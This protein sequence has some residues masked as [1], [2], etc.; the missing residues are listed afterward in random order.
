MTGDQTDMVA[1]LKAVLPRGW[2]ADDTPLLDGVLAG[3][4]CGWAWLYQSLQ[5]VIT[6]TRIATA[7]DVW[8]DVIA[9]DYFGRRLVRTPGQAD[10]PF[11]QRI[12]AEL[13]RER[14]TRAAI[15]SVLE[16][17]TGRSPV[18]FEPA[19][20]TDTGAYGTTA[21]GW[22]GLAYGAAGGWGSLILPFQVFVTAYRPIGSGIA[23]V[24][25]WG[26]GCGGYNA[27]ALE[28]GN[29]A[30]LQGQVTDADIAAATAGVLPIATIGWLQITN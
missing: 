12:L 7:S 11:R 23:F 9:R 6:Q 18:V 26:S 17:L 19:R 4:G 16:D 3:L 29:L 8:L 24:A 1:R 28:Y 27:G 22:S 14:G 20:A 30:M 25:G 10:G 13:L 21:G 2:F 15:V 5:Y